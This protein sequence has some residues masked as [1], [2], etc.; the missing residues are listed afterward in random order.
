[1]H[2]SGHDSTVLAHQAQ[3]SCCDTDGTGTAKGPLEES[4]SC[5]V[6][7]SGKPHLVDGGVA[8][9]PRA[10]AGVGKHDAVGV[11]SQPGHHVHLRNEG[12]HDTKVFG[13]WLLKP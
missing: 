8:D 5:R 6:W 12:R 11:H 10:L 4:R 9:V 13:A 1:M 3:S 7:A 2:L